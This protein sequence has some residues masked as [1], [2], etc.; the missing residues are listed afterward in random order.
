MLINSF[1]QQLAA[2]NQKVFLNTVEFAELYTII[3]D[4]ETYKD[5]PAVL[6]G[7]EQ[8]ERQRIEAD[9]GEGLYQVSTVLYCAQADLGG[10]QPEQGSTIKINDETGSDFF[11]K[12]RVASSIC[13][14]GMLEIE[15][16]RVGQ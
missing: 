2:D 3:Y 16:E 12:Y 7:V 13:E 14:I 11:I 6:T 9:H 4:G 5:V 8:K 15:L 10:V 1:K